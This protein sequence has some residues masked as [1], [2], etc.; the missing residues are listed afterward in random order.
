MVSKS[1]R[2]HVWMALLASWIGSAEAAVVFNDAVLVRGPEALA[3]LDLPFDAPGTY[4]V[5]ATDMNWLGTPLAALSFG[6]F[7]STQALETRI[8]A[9]TIEFFHASSGRVFLQLY[10]RTGAPRYAGLI[11]V[12][13]EMVNVVP[14]P[15]SLLLLASSLG[16]AGLARLCGRLRAV[17]E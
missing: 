8:G 2:L 4:R 1:I 7:T 17:R 11:V 12:R 10:A 3:V 15:A 13:G 14:L 9:G 16:V 5:T 6:A